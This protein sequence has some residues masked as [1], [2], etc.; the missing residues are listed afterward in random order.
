M[1]VTGFSMGG[2]GTWYMSSPTPGPVHARR[3]RWPPGRIATTPLKVG[4]MPV[5]I[6]HA[7]DDEVVPF[8]PAEELA[9]DD[10]GHGDRPS[11]FMPLEGVGH[12]QMGAP[13]LQ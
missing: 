10:G 7:R 8:G 3:F 12:F 13:P 9:R 6:I 5:Y 11:S 2:R 4:D 1:L